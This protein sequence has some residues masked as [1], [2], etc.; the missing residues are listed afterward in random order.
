MQSCHRPVHVR[1]EAVRSD[2]QHREGKTTLGINKTESKQ[3][4]TAFQRGESQHRNLSTDARVK[5][6]LKHPPGR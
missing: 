5:S 2:K 6:F 4:R 1:G 3:G